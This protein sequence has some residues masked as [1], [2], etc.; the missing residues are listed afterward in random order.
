MKK[1]PNVRFKRTESANRRVDESAKFLFLRFAAAQFHRFTAQ[2][3]VG[4]LVA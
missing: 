1:T 4:L 3:H 2:L